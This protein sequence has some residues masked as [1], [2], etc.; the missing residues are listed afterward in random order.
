[1][2]VRDYLTQQKLPLDRLFLGATKVAPPDDKW[3][4]RADLSLSMR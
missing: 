4:P 3:K 1:V 2:A